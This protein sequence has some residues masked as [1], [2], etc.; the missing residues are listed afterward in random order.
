[1]DEGKLRKLWEE[2]LGDRELR[3]LDPG[4]TLPRSGAQSPA[5]GPGLTL[6]TLVFRA[7]SDPASAAQTMP[8]PGP[9]DSAAQAMPIPGPSDSAAKTMPIPGPSDSAAKTMPVPSPGA[10]S[11]AATRDVGYQIIE[12][13]GRGGMGVVFRAEQRSLR[14][15]V[16]V[17]KIHSDALESRQRFISEALVTGLLDH[18]NI[19]PIHDLGQ[20]P[21]GEVLLAMKLVSGTSW[22]ELLHPK[23]EASRRRAEAMDIESQIEILLAVCNAMSFAHDHGVVHN[24]LKPENVMIGLYGE[25]FVMDWGIAVDVRDDPSEGLLTSHKS[26]IRSPCGTPSY[27]APELAEGMGERIGPWTDVYLLGAILHEIVNGRPPHQGDSIIRVILKAAESAPPDFDESVPPGLA[28]ICTKALAAEPEDRYGEVATFREELA[29]FLKHR[30]SE[31][32][33]RDAAEVLTRCERAPAQE[34]EEQRNERY[35]D[36]AEAVAGYR[37]SLILWSENEAAK[38]GERRARLAFARSALGNGDLGLAE[39]QLTRLS[40]GTEAAQ[41][42]NQVSEAQAGRVATARQSKLLRRG[43]MALTAALLLGLGLGYLLVSQERDRAQL[44]ARKARRAEGQA[45]LAERSARAARVRAETARQRAERESERARRSESLARRERRAARRRL[46]D[47]LISQGGALALAKRWSEA[48]PLYEQAR[49]IL[50]ETGGST[51]PVQLGEFDLHQHSPPPLA[52]LFRAGWP[53]YAIDCSPLGSVAA[54]GLGSGNAMLFDPKS[55]RRLNMFGSHRGA[56]HDL[57]FS[58]DG[59]AL[60]TGG[61]D[62]VLRVWD[63]ASGRSRRFD[64]KK[65]VEKWIKE[66]RIRLLRNQRLDYSIRALA[67]SPDGHGVA[68]GGDDGNIRIWNPRMNSRPTRVLYQS[69]SSLQRQA[70]IRALAWSPGG[71]YLAAGTTGGR[72]T[73][74][75]PAVARLVSTPRL[76]VGVTALRFSPD[77]K[78]LVAA[79]RGGEMRSWELSSGRL[80]RVMRGHAGAILGMDLSP[81]GETLV[82]VGVDTSLRVWDL[83]SG[84]MLRATPTYPQRL[85]LGRLSE[86]LGAHDQSCVAID[87]SGTLMLSGAGNG[88]V[89]LWKMDAEPGLRRPLDISRRSSHLSFIDGGQCAAVAAEGAL[90]IW[91]LQAGRRLHRWRDKAYYLRRVQSLPG[92]ELRIAFSRGKELG[93]WTPR[94]ERAPRIFGRHEDTIQALL[95]LPDGSLIASD[96]GGTVC[97]WDVQQGVALMSIKLGKDEANTL[98]ADSAGKRLLAAGGQQIALIDL[99]GS[100]SLLRTATLK[101]R[102]PQELCFSQN[103]ESMLAASWRIGVIDL[104]S[105]PLKGGETRMRR[106]VGHRDFVQELRFVNQGRLLLSASLDRSLR[107]WNVTSGREVHSLQPAGRP[108]LGATM[109]P[110]GKTIVTI[111]R[112]GLTLIDLEL[113]RRI[114]SVRAEDTGLVA[115]AKEPDG[116]EELDRAGRWLHLRGLNTWAGTCFLAAGKRDYRAPPQLPKA[117]ALWAAGQPAAA[118]RSLALAQAAGELPAWRGELTKRALLAAVARIASSVQV[119]RLDRMIAAGDGR[120]VLIAGA[121][122]SISRRVVTTGELLWRG[123]GHQTRITSLTR[124]GDRPLLASASRDGELRSWHLETGR[125]AGLLGKHSRSIGAIASSSDGRLLAA[126]D[127]LGKIGL[128]S[129]DFR[130][131]KWLE[132]HQRSINALAFNADD[133]WLLSGS[134]DG[135][136]RL[137]ERTSGRCLQVLKGHKYGAKAVAFLPDGAPVSI[138]SRGTIRVWEPDGR[139]RRSVQNKP[140]TKLLISRDG[141]RFITAGDRG[142]LQAFGLPGWRRLP[143]V[144]HPKFGS[145]QALCLSSWRNKVLIANYEGDLSCLQYED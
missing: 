33:A 130:R 65:S 45:R 110:S 132:G 75:E 137:W 69:Q 40:G 19:V 26:T 55:G 15:Q 24:D 122:F 56:I 14:R 11:S 107:V 7:D 20:T 99:S 89:R 63:M 42:R 121:D 86:R 90:E 123:Y 54:L 140:L 30:E 61:A 138:D 58:P 98:H 72:V 84:T 129:V 74:W 8:V 21:E 127:R 135:S 82:S 34:G 101:A 141:R 1:V 92:S 133:R 53:I 85:G 51:L 83:N 120:S 81:N 76:G 64:V 59:L 103:G 95:L 114:R 144:T 80:L 104:E 111:D 66:R 4:A 124:L 12:E 77:S 68:T 23:T 78:I 94:T 125:S 60:A 50:E 43:L 145:I 117:H 52:T 37:Q 48:Q 25:V 116:G 118:Q 108:L 10:L 6:P 136:A 106:F 5:S 91:D 134:D 46:A 47:G 36:F 3:E 113:A 17:K 32:I 139:L 31:V 49:T 115:L 13:I 2:S 57:A 35:A 88:T 87:P 70:R 16:A 18:P 128:W 97:R 9:S 29:A 67:W 22:D 93:L 73:V 100:G 119:G 126:G 109:A 38:G 142:R 44:S 28:A 62:G 131:V 79:G 27:M 41:L 102:N 112:G 143:G 71:Q 39:A 96:S 105:I